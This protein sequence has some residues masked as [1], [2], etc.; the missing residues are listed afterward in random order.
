MPKRLTVLQQFHRISDFVHHQGQAYRTDVGHV[1][2]I[3]GL[4]PHGISHRL[5]FPPFG[6]IFSEG[7]RSV[8]SDVH[9]M[10]LCISGM[11]V[12]C[13]CVLHFGLLG[14]PE[15]PVCVCLCAYACMNSALEV[16]VLPPR[17]DVTPASH[18]ARVP[19]T[20]RG[21]RMPADTMVLRQK[22]MTRLMQISL[23]L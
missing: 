14:A 12:V 6:A 11:H 23:C 17:Q 7:S 13:F 8:S 19:S 21:C 16:A 4:D 18:N 1:H 2:R 3:W 5:G 15:D 20:A 9:P 22:S 10:V